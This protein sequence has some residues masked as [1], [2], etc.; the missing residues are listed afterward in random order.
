MS[1]RKCI[2]TGLPATKTD[3][4]VP[5]T[6]GDESHNWVNSVPCSEEYKEIKK[7]KEPNDLEI[8]A[9]DT[10][11]KLEL[12]RLQ[13]ERYER[14]LQDV[15]TRIRKSV[16]LDKPKKPKKLS[17]DKQIEIAYKEKEIV[18]ADFDR[19]IKEKKKKMEW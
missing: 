7:R 19:V 10:F 3:M 17:K 9:N 5:K 8:E 6:G 12:A 4:V 13:V 14:A 11:R 2:Y 15:Q 18:E 1:Q 16:G